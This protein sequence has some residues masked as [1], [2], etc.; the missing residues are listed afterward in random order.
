[1]FEYID[2]Q[3]R[4]GTHCKDDI[5]LF[6]LSTC[7]FCKRA[8]SFLDERNIQ[9]DY[10]FVN[11]LDPEL[12]KRA[13]EEFRAKFDQRMNF[14][15][16]V[17]NEFDYQIGFIRVA[18]ERLFPSTGAESERSV[19]TESKSSTDVSKFVDA[20]AAYK[21]WFVNPDKDFRQDL[22]EGLLSN[23]KKY[24]FYHCPCRDAEDENENNKD[25]ACPCRYSE[26]D[27]TE[28]GQCF[29]GLFVSKAF[30]DSRT[31]LGSI[32]ERRDE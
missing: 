27:I 13:K 1:M 19:P 25:I 6:G 11:E 26:D 10:V 2:F 31:E 5:K 32:P 3:R 18:L 20:A 21:G 30:H 14:P 29:C 8:M 12:K 16:L 17:I 9:Y 15:T 22:E 23:Y 7:A 4:E 24:G 28:W